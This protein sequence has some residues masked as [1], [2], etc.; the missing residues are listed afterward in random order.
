MSASQVFI[1]AIDGSDVSK[2]AAAFAAGRARSLEAKLILAHVVD[3]SGFEHLTISE[4]GERHVQKEKEVEA[5]EQQILGPILADIQGD[6]IIIETVVRHGH[7]VETLC[8]LVEEYG[9]SQVFTGKRGLGKLS[10]LLVGSV[11]SGLVQVCDVPVT[12]IP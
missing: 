5:A 4:L 9:A 2:R 8:A 3:W 1:V 7:P 11:S 12:I 10:S 6:D